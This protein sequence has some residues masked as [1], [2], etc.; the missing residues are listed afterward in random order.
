M[1][2]KRKL[3]VTFSAIIIL[4]LF[5]AV[6]AYCAFAWFVLR[7]NPPTEGLKEF[8]I[9]VDAPFLSTLFFLI[10]VILIITAI[11]LTNWIVKKHQPEMALF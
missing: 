8:G 6:I 3:F 10:L 9:L 7:G 4:P 1:T 2:F 11:L 5:L